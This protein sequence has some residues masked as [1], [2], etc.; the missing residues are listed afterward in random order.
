M[1][2][3][4]A[5]LPQSQIAE[6]FFQVYRYGQITKE[7]RQFLKMFLLQE[8]LPYEERTAIDRMIYAVR[9]GWLKIAE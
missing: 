7:Q 1:M 5:L 6:L 9:R 2:I 4:T 8:T 3:D